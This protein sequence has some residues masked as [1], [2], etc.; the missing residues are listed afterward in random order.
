MSAP[1]PDLQNLYQQIVLDH[2]RHPRNQRR[3]D[4][5]DREAEG[6]NPL[7]GDKVRVFLRITDDRLEDVAFEA[8]GCAICLASASLMTEATCGHTN[9]DVRA[10]ATRFTQALDSRGNGLS[11]DLAALSAVS[12]YPSRIR[13]ATLPWKTLVAALDTSPDTVTTEPLSSPP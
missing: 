10:S 1:A 7:C 6:H 12:H 9:P 4:R 11:G 3:P 13:C 5:Y 2:S 8:S